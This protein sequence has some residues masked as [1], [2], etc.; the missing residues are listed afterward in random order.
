MSNVQRALGTHNL[1]LVGLLH[2]VLER[3]LETHVLLEHVASGLVEVSASVRTYSYKYCT[4]TMLILLFNV[5][6]S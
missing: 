1:E 4:R 5:R 3:L 6:K 2:V